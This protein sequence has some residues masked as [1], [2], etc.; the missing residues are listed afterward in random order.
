MKKSYISVF[1]I[2]AIIFAAV[3]MWNY[4]Y[5]SGTWRYKITVN[6]KT[7]DGIATGSAVRE[8]QVSAKPPFS[9]PDVKPSIRVRGEAVV[10]ELDEKAKIYAIITPND[11]QMIL[12]AFPNHGGLSP[13]GIRY[14]NSLKNIS[15]VL[16]LNAYPRI[17]AFK[18]INDPKTVFEPYKVIINTEG[19]FNERGKV[20][21]VEDNLAASFGKD[22]QLKDVT[23]EM[24]NEPITWTI[25]TSLPWIDEYYYKLLDGHNNHFSKAQYPVANSLGSGSFSTG[26]KN[27]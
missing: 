20:L 16:P 25:S 13:K 3:V 21:R 4:S 12:K 6:V 14:Y 24:T 22:L 15:T 17:V 18:N 23:L 19:T 8:V 27:E 2:L 11:W 7:P 5:P 26:G 10:V 9:P 1:A